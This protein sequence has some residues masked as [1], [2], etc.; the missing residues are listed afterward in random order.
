MLTDEWDWGEYFEALREES[1][2]IACE[3]GHEKDWDQ[4]MEQAARNLLSLGMPYRFIVQVT[5]LTIE[6]IYMLKKCK[7][8]EY[9]EEAHDEGWEESIKQVAMCLLAMRKTTDFIVQATGLPVKKI[10]DLAFERARF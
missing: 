9:M 10:N 3:Q 4:G 8:E 5:G 6:K 7:Q 1:R 2:E